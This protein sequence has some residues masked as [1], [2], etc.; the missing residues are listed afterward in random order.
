MGMLITEIRS[1]GKEASVK[2]KD[3]LLNVLQ[4]IY[5]LYIL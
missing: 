3:T 5:I 4:L 2:W 1:T